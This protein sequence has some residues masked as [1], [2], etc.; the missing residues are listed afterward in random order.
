ME[1][2]EY[3]QENALLQTSFGNL[4]GHFEYANESNLYIT[5]KS[6]S[7]DIFETNTIK[8]VDARQENM[9]F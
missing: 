5:R 4:G 3:R 6:S 2:V 1:T 9:P 8:T 7:R